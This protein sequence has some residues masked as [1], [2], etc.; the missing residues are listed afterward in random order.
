MTTNLTR[1]HNKQPIEIGNCVSS[2][3]NDDDEDDTGGLGWAALR[4]A[5]QAGDRDKCRDL[6]KGATG[7]APLALAA[8][9]DE[10]E[11]VRF[12]VNNVITGID[13]KDV[14]YNNDE[15]NEEEKD[16]DRDDDDDG[17]EDGDED[18]DDMR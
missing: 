14:E 8:Q 1:R 6:V 13:R 11:I 7:W 4:R 16:G 17:D 18:R 15:D 12:L 10:L 9:R 2:R 5:V 3:Y